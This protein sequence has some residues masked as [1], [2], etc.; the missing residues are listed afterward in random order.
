MPVLLLVVLLL[1]VLA[2]AGASIVASA[3]EAKRLALLQPQVA[4]AVVRLQTS[5]EQDEKIRTFVGSTVR[6]DAEQ[7]AAY[8]SGNSSTLDSWHEV[9]RAVDLYVYGPDGQVDR[10]G[11]HEALWLA[12]HKKAARFGFR[13][14]AYNADWS[15]RWITNAAGKKVR[16]LGHLEYREALTFSQAVAQWRALHPPKG[17]LA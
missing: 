9:G 4:A 1:V 5:L 10:A 15:P 11:R 17:G 14:I 12:M 6:T 2:G 13:G 16:D 3:A 7:Q 8:D